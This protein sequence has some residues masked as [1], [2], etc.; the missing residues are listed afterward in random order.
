MVQLELV[1][2]A[3]RRPQSLY[4]AI[5][6]VAERAL[7][8]SEVITWPST[9]W[10]E[11]P[12]AF[13][14]D[15]LGI[16]LWS[17]QVEILEA[18]RDNRNVTVRS[19]HKCG[20]S[21]ALAVAALWFFCSFDRARV[22]LTAV[23]S[24]QIDEVIWKEIRRLYR[25][26][27]IPLGGELFVLARTGLRADDERQVF[28]LTA[29]DGEGL[30]GISG[31][32]ILILCDEASG[33]NDRF[34][35]TLGSSL[36]GSGGTARK[37][38]ISNPTR[39]QGEFYK[40]HTVN[41]GLF[42]CIHVSSEDTPNAR[43]TGEIPGLAG[44]DWIAE[45]KIEYGEDSPQYRV[46]VKGEFVADRDGRIN[47][48]DVIAL[49]QAAWE[50]APEEGQLQIGL[51]PAGDGIKGDATA[52]SVRRGM[53]VK[54]VVAE[55]GLSEDAIVARTLDLLKM[56]LKPRDRL[57]RVV[58]DVGGG[59]GTRVAAK[60]QAYLDLHH[61][62]FELVQLR[63]EKPAWG[64]VDYHTVGDALWGEGSEWIKAG[65]AIPEDTKLE[66]ELNAPSFVLAQG[67][68]G[69]QRYTLAQKKDVL[70]KELGRSP[71]RADAL[72]LSIYGW[73]TD[74]EEPDTGGSDR[75]KT[76][77]ELAYADLD[78]DDLSPYDRADVSPYGG[79][80]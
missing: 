23:K 78:D 49:A 32:N 13:A 56:H 29:R 4:Q 18:I 65:G 33:I 69:N 12:V 46:R 63:S 50:D 51:D 11:D 75:T 73:K 53:K 14:R 41:A 16:E 42:K 70:R 67:R 5:E 3:R 80:F 76:S 35:E 60:L 6:W 37:C 74:G 64:N 26:A 17:A 48:L 1:N 19:G 79:S 45:K 24:T 21:T 31:P 68:D 25:G 38:Y 36:A 15:V 39:T 54:R 71:D 61:E 9:R 28:G 66:Q 2:P 59:I 43:G 57:A 40:S 30:A 20:K 34:F 44:P 7:A 52:H 72:N 22:L 27:K 47:S 10:R 8:A 55:R 58:L 62:A 77:G